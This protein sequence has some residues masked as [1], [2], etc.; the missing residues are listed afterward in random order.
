MGYHSN[1]ARG[2]TITVDPETGEPA[3][4]LV[5][6][7]RA[8]GAEFGVRT[9]RVKGLQSTVA[10]WYLGFDSELLFI[11]DAGITE[12]SRPSRRLGVEWTNYARLNPW[13][14]AELDL[15]FSRAQFTDDQAPGSDIP[16][17]LDRVI[18]GALTVEPDTPVFGSIRLRHF[19]PRPLIEDASVRSRSTTIW[20]GEIGYR[21]SDRARLT[22]AGFNLFDS[23]VSDIDYFYTS[24][25]PGEP[26]GGVD[27]I[28][29]HPSLPRSARVTLQVSF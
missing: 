10:L 7:V 20:N 28:H 29:L 16:G 17:A 19:G 11:G 14:T 3:E 22:L 5:P 24:R 15:S 9:V 8:K 13:L 4:P 12:A 1:D 2:A 6:L 27:D 23:D 26:L 25:L 21:F 18:S